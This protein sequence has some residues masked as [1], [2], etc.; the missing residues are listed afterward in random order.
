MRVDGSQKAAVKGAVA[1]PEE[2]ATASWNVTGSRELRDAARA[3]AGEEGQCL[4]ELVIEAVRAYLAG[5]GETLP[6]PLPPRRY[7]P[8]PGRVQRASARVRVDGPLK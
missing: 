6:P 5:K 2:D 1:P 3:Y 4:S 7:G 8:A